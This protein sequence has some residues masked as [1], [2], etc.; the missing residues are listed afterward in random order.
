MARYSSRGRSLVLTALLIPATLSSAETPDWNNNFR[1]GVTA[2]SAGHYK[3]AI[4]LLTIA[5]EQAKSLPEPEL[6]LAQVSHVLAMSYQF[7]GDLS[8]A[9]PLYLRV[10]SILEPLGSEG[11]DLLAV[12]LSGL[13]L[14]R[15]EQG[16]WKEA[17]TTLTRAIDLCLVSR[18]GNDRCILTATRNLGDLYAAEGRV[19]EASTILERAVN[20][21]RQVPALPQDLSSA[22]LRSLAH[23]Y[24]QEGV[25]EKAEPLLQEALQS[26]SKSGANDLSYADSLFSLGRMYR[27]EGDTARAEP[28][29]RKAAAI[30][31]GAGD[32]L[33]ATAW[34][35]LGMIAVEDH[36]YTTG[37]GLILRSLEL[38]RKTFGEDHITVA[39]GQSDLAQAYLGER[40]YSEA[41]AQIDAA[42]TS[43]RRLLGEAH[44][45]VAR[46]HMIAA[47]IEALLHHKPEA[48][49]HYRAA[50]SIF[51]AS[52]GNNNPD[53]AAAEREYRLFS[54]SF[55]K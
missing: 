7:L 45:A 24:M 38:N 27:M 37:R 44:Y 43:Q 47:E 10:Q 16:K 4:D 35:E 13:G 19:N 9:E 51:R 5:S 28:L 11:R 53:L 55:A 29:V 6:K 52:F 20:T 49:Q 12:T 14:L 8:H 33:R 15:V 34:D 41:R 26:T 54:K 18:G 50:L 39:Q 3:D 48:D 25:Y 36:K 31:E 23:V 32:P 21:S 2:F 40:K 1:E 46:S 30:Y 22:L 42:L 17:E